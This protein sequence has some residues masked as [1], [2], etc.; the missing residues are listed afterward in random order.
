MLQH[1]IQAEG[2][3][4]QRYSKKKI[5]FFPQAAKIE[6]ETHFVLFFSVTLVFSSSFVPPF[7]SG[8]LW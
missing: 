6:K 8:C 1:F 4:D 3:K 7:L 5:N 2:Q